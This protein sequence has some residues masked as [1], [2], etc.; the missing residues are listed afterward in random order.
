M[1]KHP[2]SILLRPLGILY[3]LIA[4]IRNA[5]FDRGLFTPW[6][7][8]CPVVSIGNITAGGTGKTPMVDWTTK[9]FLSLGC[10]VAII[11]RGYGRNTKGVRL[12]SDGRHLLM[13]AREAGDETTMLAANNPE[14]I[15]VVAE[16]RREGARFI[17]KTFE[18]F[19]PHVIILDDAF[20]HRQMARDLDIVIINASEPFF[21]AR[22]LPEGRLREPLRNLARADIILLGKI[23][24]PDEADAIEQA[25]T[26]TNL[27]V[28]RTRVQT[29]GLQPA[30]DAAPPLPALAF[31]GIAAPEE[32]LASLRKTGAEVRAHRF[33]RDHQPFTSEM[34]RSLIREAQEKGLCLV[35]TE[36]DWF[37]LLGDPQLK[38]LMEK[39]GCRYLKI[40][41]RLPE[42]DE[43][44]RMTFRDLV[45]R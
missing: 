15:V 18:N 14:A 40:E 4:D 22:M 1:H 8:P 13:N 34:V 42:G 25:L 16:K 43:K 39:A 37:R 26:A 29:L 9:Y 21:K 3:G 45:G 33:F 10:R 20:Q 35:T 12:V 41:T 24:D 23:T 32:F 7:A 5:L 36:K 44:L 30:P 2:L 17:Q 19:P 11:S 38:E 27:P 31:A 6:R 28:L